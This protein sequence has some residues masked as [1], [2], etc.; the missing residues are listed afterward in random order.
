MNE[1]NRRARALLRFWPRVRIGGFLECWEWTGNR[2]PFG[3]ARF[4]F[5]GRN[6]TAQRVAWTLTNGPIPNG[7]CVLH[8][9][10]NPPCVNPAHLFLGTKSDNSL[11]RHAKGRTIGGSPF[12]RPGF[13]ARGERGGNSKLTEAEV[14][15]ILAEFNS[16]SVYLGTLAKKYHV[17]RSTVGRI[18]SGKLWAHVG[19]N[20]NAA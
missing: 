1:D 3:Y 10:D 15:E 11:D 12:I 16:T 9:C 8:R 5:E 17:S 20:T 7:L 2:E 13:R 19:R 4:W 14:T 6:S 18:I